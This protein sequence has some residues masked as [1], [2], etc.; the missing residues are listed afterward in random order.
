MLVGCSNKEREEELQKQLAQVRAADSTLQVGITDRDKFM[1]QVMAAVNESYANLEKARV[2][3][4]GLAERATGVEGTA[5]TSSV[6]TRDDLLKDLRE[7]S[8]TLEGDRKRIGA[9]QLK[10]RS[11]GKQ[12]AGLDTLIENLKGSLR[13]RETSIAQLQFRIQG[14]EANVAENVK[15]IAVK[16]STIQSQTR[17]LNT[18]Y[19]VIGTKDELKKKGIITDEGGFLWGL[20]GSTTVMSDSLDDSAFAPLDR[21]KEQSIQVR[22][23]IDQILPKRSPDT[24]AVQGSDSAL[25]IISPQKFWQQ[26]YLVIVVGS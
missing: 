22:G 1:E 7:I 24:F 2:R 18:A 3:E 15:T 25:T 17:T 23:K 8:T 9:L 10:N 26:R 13:T 16:D 14:L 19:Y 11:Y 20:L 4:G 6:A 5:K 21:T 12:L